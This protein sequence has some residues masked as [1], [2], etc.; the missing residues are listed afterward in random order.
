[1]NT[2]L[3]RGQVVHHRLA[4]F[5]RRFRKRLWMAYLDL[6]ELPGLA[7]SRWRRG[8]M[9][10]RRTDHLGPHDEAL[11][12][13][14]RKLVARETGLR[15]EGPVRLL[16]ML[17]SFGVSFNPVSFFYCFAP[18]GEALEAVVAEVTNTP[19]GE[20]HCYVLRPSA[21]DEFESFEPKAFHV[22]PFMGMEQQYRF[23]IGRPGDRLALSIESCEAD[24]PVFRAALDLRRE[25]WT[26]E[27]RLRAFARHPVMPLEV[28]VAIYWQ[29]FRLSLLRAPFHPHP[30]PDRRTLEMAP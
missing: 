5:E 2:C 25:S 11:D 1:M 26:P 10:F 12:E 22:S 24:Q 4:P 21:Q 15:P 3:Y 7:L 16:S 19:W 8:P 9:T 20:R 27:S 29:A 6:S 13:S 30:G 18:D 23:R 17:R 28:A 14:V